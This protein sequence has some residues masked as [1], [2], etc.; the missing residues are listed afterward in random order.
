[1]KKWIL[2]FCLGMLFNAKSYA[3]AL[4]YIDSSMV[5]FDTLSTG[6]SFDSQWFIANNGNKPLVIDSV[7]FDGD[8]C[9]AYWPQHPL[10][11][12]DTAFIK[13]A[14]QCNVSGNYHRNVFIQT[15]SG[16]KENALYKIRLEAYI[17]DEK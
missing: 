11:P 4:L 2:V 7:F 6:S 16:K 3:Q 13:I 12:D 15:N 1:M 17:K 5:S 9:V 10:N 8:F 14:C